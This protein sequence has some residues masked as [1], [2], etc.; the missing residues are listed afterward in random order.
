MPERVSPRELSEGD[1]VVLHWSPYGWARR[2]DGHESPVTATVTSVAGT[3]M[4]GHMQ[5][6]SLRTQGGRRYTHY[7]DNGYINGSA[8][9][10]PD[11]P[12]RTDV[13]R[14]RYY[15]YAR[16]TAEEQRKD[17]LG[18]GPRYGSVGSRNSDFDIGGGL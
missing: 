10:D 7:V 13:G 9:G 11:V 16:A 18:G 4:G 6:V 15:E 2:S 5:D 14:F 12:G 1:R 17:A 3:A 8:E